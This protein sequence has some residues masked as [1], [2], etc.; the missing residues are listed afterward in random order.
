MLLRVCVRVRVRGCAWVAQVSALRVGAEEVDEVL[1]PL[2]SIP[3]EAGV[4]ALEGRA[5]EQVRPPCFTSTDEHGDTRYIS[6]G[7]RQGGVV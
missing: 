7:Y 3:E 2:G 5:I 4:G 1:E 6:H